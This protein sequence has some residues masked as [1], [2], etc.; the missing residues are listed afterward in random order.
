M[1][2]QRFNVEVRTE[3]E[4]AAHRPRRSAADVRDLRTGATR[5]EPYD[6]LVLSPGAAPIRPPL[7]GSTCRGCSRC[8]AFPTPAASARW[9]D[10]RSAEAAVVVG[11]GFIGLEMVENLVHRGLVG[12]GPRE[13]A[14]GDA[15]ARRGDG[16]AH[17]KRHL[18]AQRRA[19]S[20]G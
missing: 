10:E 15:A 16:G 14:A 7:P 13:A 3:H 2:R 11:G 5:D 8:A 17:C 19:A 1:F 20:S 6:V 18:A 9:I 4:V 12:D